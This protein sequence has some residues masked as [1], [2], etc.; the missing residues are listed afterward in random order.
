MSIEMIM[1]IVVSLIVPSCTRTYVFKVSLLPERGR[2]RKIVGA[3]VIERGCR[4][5]E[6]KRECVWT[7]R[8]RR[9]E[10]EGQRENSENERVC[11]QRA[12]KA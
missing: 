6:K 8:K 9:G 5:R 10:R 12:K 11:M 1:F 7:L 4:E 2:E 3:R